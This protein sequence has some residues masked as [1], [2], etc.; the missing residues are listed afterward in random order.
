MRLIGI[1]GLKTSGKDSTYKAIAAALPDKR[2]RRVAFADKLKE[3]GAL[4]MGIYDNPLAE[5]DKAKESWDFEVWE[6]LENGERRRLKITGREYLQNIGSEARGLFGLSF[7]VD[8]ILP[9]PYTNP[10]VETGDDEKGLQL[11]G[12]Y[13]CV[14]IL[15]VTDVRYPNEADRVHELGGEIWNIIRP[16]TESDGHSSEI[17]LDSSKIDLT[18]YNVYDIETLY[19]TV[20]E[21]VCV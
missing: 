3:L 17:P 11:G 18:I 12:R 14:D 2:V 5:M 21:T 15:C 8:Q 1:S 7:W 4:A 16:G 13:P 19:K 6:K 20:A 10:Y 9:P